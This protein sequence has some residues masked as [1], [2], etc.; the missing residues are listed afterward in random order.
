MEKTPADTPR[1]DLA[2]LRPK[3]V[4]TALMVVGIMIVLLALASLLVQPKTETSVFGL[5]DPGVSGIQA[6]PENSIDVL[7]VGDSLVLNGYLP[8]EAWHECGYTSYVLSTLGQKLPDGNTI[9]HLALHNQRPTVI[10]FEAEP[11]MAGTTFDDVLLS[12]TCRVFPVFRYHSRWRE[13]TSVDFTLQ[14]QEYKRSPYHGCKPEHASEPV[15]KRTLAAYM[16]PA[17]EWASIDAFS[18]WYFEQMLGYCR[19][20]GATPV[21]FSAPCPKEWSMAKHNA[22]SA[23]AEEHNLD[24]YDLNLATDEIGIDWETDFTDGG[25]HLNVRGATKM[26]LY[27]G[28]LLDEYYKLPDHRNN[29]SYALWDEDYEMLHEDIAADTAAE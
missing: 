25:E 15:S 26:T 29:E 28:K 13:L 8:H 11:V 20:V 10:L 17:L 6:E 19:S 22:M 4:A 9:L 24:Y 18:G 14:Q 12:A 5:F 16:K 3:T 21:L 23:W 27:L 1:E 7:V 2:H